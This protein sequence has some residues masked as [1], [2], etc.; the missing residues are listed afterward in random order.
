MVYTVL[1]AG[2]V[3][4]KGMYIEAKGMYQSIERFT[5][6]APCQDQLHQGLQGEMSQL[7]QNPSRIPAQ[8]D[9]AE[10]WHAECK[11][12]F[13]FAELA[14]GKA[15]VLRS[16]KQRHGCVPSAAESVYTIHH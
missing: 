8:Q 11:R 1:M 3:C 14:E 4:W 9:G 16:R 2:K 10:D 13:S 7:W 15:T 12:C 6:A 5:E